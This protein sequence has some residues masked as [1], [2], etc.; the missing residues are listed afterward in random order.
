[1]VRAMI[2]RFETI[3]RAFGRCRIVAAAREWW[4]GTGT[5]IIARASNAPPPIAG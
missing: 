4:R 1:M 5:N 3:G 2:N